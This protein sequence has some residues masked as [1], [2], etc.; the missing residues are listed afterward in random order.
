MDFLGGL[1]DEAASDA[2]PS[3]FAVTAI[4]PDPEQPR[5]EIDQERHD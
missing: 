4:R 1:G 5:T 2:P 3:M